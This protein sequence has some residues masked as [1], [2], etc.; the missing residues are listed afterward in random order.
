[1]N[2]RTNSK[3]NGATTEENIGQVPQTPV[4]IHAQYLK[5]ISFENPNA[6]AILRR[7][8]ERPEMDMDI[9]LNVERL[10]NEESEY[11]YEVSL[12][13]NA[14]AVR[15]G[16]TMF[17]AE[18][19]Y[20]AAVSINGMEEKMHHPLLL[21]EVPQM[22]FPFARLILSNATQAGGFMPLQLAPVDFRT[23][24]ME[25]FGNK[26]QAE[27]SAENSPKDAVNQ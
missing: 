16:Q 20:C 11:F 7:G 19:T 6:P 4:M 9:S 14:S 18:I 10:E 25:R 3:E 2:D 12:M 23:M 22:I 24:Y 8:N 5:D 17:I 15:E 13:M 21:I 1:M 26:E 27:E